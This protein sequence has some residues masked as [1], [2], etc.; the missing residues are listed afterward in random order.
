MSNDLNVSESL[1]AVFGL[2]S[3]VNRARPTKASALKALTAFARF[4]GVLGC[5]GEEPSGEQAV[6]RELEELLDQR[7][8]ARK[9]KDFAA[10]DQLRDRIQ[11]QGYKIVDTK[12]GARLERLS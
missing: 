7:Q 1:A 11:E 10:A 6:P 12:D 5:L 4:E 2:V 8:A 9:A 3:E